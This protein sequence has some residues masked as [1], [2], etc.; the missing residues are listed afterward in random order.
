MCDASDTPSLDTC[1]PG[2]LPPPSC[3]ALSALG[4]FKVQA[5]THLLPAER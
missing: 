2:L 4:L 1:L 5:L 3:V